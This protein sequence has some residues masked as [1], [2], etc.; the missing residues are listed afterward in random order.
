MSTELQDKLDSDT[1][2]PHGEQLRVLL[3]SDHITYGEALG[4]L[5]AK[6]VFCSITEKSQTIPILASTILKPNEFT[7]LL[8]TSVSRESIKKSKQESI[9]LNAAD[10]NWAAAL[11]EKANDLAALARI[12]SLQG[13][14]F[15][16]NPEIRFNG[17]KDAVI[18]Y[19]INRQDYSRDLLGRDL[20][21]SGELTMS[22][23]G[24]ELVLEVSSNY[25]S[26]DTDRINAA[27]IK[28]L[29]KHFKEAGVAKTDAP[30]KI[31]FESFDNKN[32]VTFL[33]RLA[34]GFLDGDLPG[35]IIDI[36]IKRNEGVDL[37]DDPEI[38]W[39]DGKVRNMKM[40]GDQLN[41]VIMLSSEKYF[42]F[43]YITRIVVEHA[44][45]ISTT[46]GECTAVYQ[47][48]QSRSP[49]KFLRSEFTSHIESL[50]VLDSGSLKV[51]EAVKKEI[52]EL[53]RVKVGALFQELSLKIEAKEPEKVLSVKDDVPA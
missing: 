21:F 28:G 53:I 40:D 15:T 52:R 35:K 29:N 27:L 26:K 13:V 9:E 43:F 44:Y 42:D 50:S 14:K 24:S 30:V 48:Q 8:E 10:A 5:R 38:K 4:I 20:N 49:E 33:L 7:S 31:K 12:E 22:Q 11:K 18:T 39:M 36:S 51:R 45:K 41:N 19:E 23:K 37:P 32:R 2:L 17:K 1:C 47:F 3:G 25:T 16:K 46:E 34:A 6:G